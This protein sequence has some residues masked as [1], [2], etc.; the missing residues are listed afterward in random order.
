ML[1]S[2]TRARAGRILLLAGAFFAVVVAVYALHTA[3]DERE[4]AMQEVDD[5]LLKAARSIP[6]FL[7][8]D[9][10]DRAVQP[11]AISE[12]ED[13]ANIKHLSQIAN[14]LG[15]AYLYTL[16]YT[17]DAVYLTS[18]S[19]SEEEVQKKTEVRYFTA[20]P[21]VTHYVLKAIETGS[22][23]FNTYTDRWGV[24]RHVYIPMRNAKGVSYVT[25]ADQSIGHISKSINRHVLKTAY[26]IFFCLLAGLPFL[27]AYRQVLID[28]ARQLELL[29]RK[30]EDDL[31]NI[32]QAE[33]AL[34]ESEERFELAASA[35]HIGVW[36]R[37]IV[38][39]R[40]RWDQRMYQLYGISPDTFVSTYAAWE[41]CVHPED[42]QAT[43][44]AI[45]E[46]ERGKKDFDTEFRI[47]RPDGEVRHI[48]AFGKASLD[49]AGKPVR[50]TGVNFDITERNRAEEYLRLRNEELEQF[51]R[52]TAGRELR[53][54]ELKKEINQLHRQLGQAVPYVVADVAQGVSIPATGLKAFLKKLF[55]KDKPHAA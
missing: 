23:V 47:V 7:S 12:A 44:K 35:A 48:K 13:Q 5:G 26:T 37:D 51:N 39:N 29:N 6:H 50:M 28:N 30:L 33:E 36:D 25:A 45:A 31:I 11:G 49:K 40:L 3:R 14:D 24:F 20:Y 18:S 1:Y 4:E 22:P 46:A 43:A 21:E 32:K 34:I 8:P 55:G 38:N 16:V 2:K 10:F 54:I 53:M 9:F 27:F 15:L 52:A 17:N 19:A 41:Q 42:R